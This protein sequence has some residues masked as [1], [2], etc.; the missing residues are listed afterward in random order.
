MTPT[1]LTMRKILRAFGKLLVRAQGTKYW[2]PFGK[3]LQLIIHFIAVMLVLSIGAIVLAFL[4]D[5]DIMYGHDHHG[6]IDSKNKSVINSSL[7]K[8]YVESMHRGKDDEDKMFW[9]SMQNRYNY[10]VENELQHYFLKEVKDYLDR[11]YNQPKHITRIHIHRPKGIAIRDR[12]FIFMK[13]FYFATVATTTIGYGNVYPRTDEGKL[14]YIFFSIIGIVSM[15]TLLRSCGKILMDGNKKLYTLVSR[16]ICQ[17]KVYVSDQLMSV[18]SLCLV[19]LFFMLFVVWYEHR[20]GTHL[21]GK[22][23]L[24][25]TIYFWLVTFTTVGFG[26]VHFPLDVEIEHFYEL[27][28]YRIIGLSFLAAIIESIHVYI[29]FRRKLLII[30]SRPRLRKI[31]QVMRQNSSTYYKDSQQF[32]D[33]IEPHLKLMLDPGRSAGTR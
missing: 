7:S 16:R 14:F 26:D 1:N 18:V 23:S 30:H 19:F 33:D 10:T 11:R 4:E 24:L 8:R 25:D 6:A 12:G 20:I 31:A 5:P 2:Q 3:S 21:E 29:K 9:L 22:W 28:I 17:R 13:W 27:L 15:M 32:G